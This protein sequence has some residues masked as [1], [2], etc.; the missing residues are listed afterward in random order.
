MSIDISTLLVP[1]LPTLPNLNAT[2]PN[3]LDVQKVA[4]EWLNSLSS[5]I[6]S[7]NPDNA[8][9]R[10][11][12]SQRSYIAS[13]PH[14]QEHSNCV[15]ISWDYTED[16]AWINCFFDFE[17][18]TGIG[19]GIIRLKIR[20]DNGTERIFNVKHV[21]FATGMDGVEPN[22]PN[23][24]D[25][26]KVKG[27]FLHSNKYKR[28]I[29]HEEKKVVVG[30]ACTSGTKFSSF[31]ATNLL[32]EYKPTTLHMIAISMESVDT[33]FS[34]FI[35][36]FSLSHRDV[37]MYQR[38][39]TYIMRTKTG[40]GVVF[41]GL[42][43]EHAPPTDIADR[44]SASFLLYEY[45]TGP[46]FCSA[47]RRARQMPSTNVDLELTKESTVLDINSWS[48]RFLL[49]L[50][51]SSFPDVGASKL[52][53]DGK[54]KLKN[55]SQIKEFTEA[56]LL[57][58]D[59]TKLLEDVVVFATG[60]SDVKQ[61][62]R[63]ICGVEVA[64]KCLPIWGLNKGE[65]NDS[66]RDLGVQGL[67]YMTGNLALCR[68]HSKHVAPHQG[69]GRGSIRLITSKNLTLLTSAFVFHS[70]AWL[71]LVNLRLNCCNHYLFA[72][73]DCNRDMHHPIFTDKPLT[74]VDSPFLST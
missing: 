74:K 39:S 27:Q 36:F 71:D 24:P 9:R 34:F 53:A 57:F 48:K 6:E 32:I 65:A 7:N 47:N 8:A 64:D 38:S 18:D 59:N 31:N 12:L 58:E 22:I 40:W 14:I 2:V 56:V 72:T 62:I 46:A 61:H 42:Y 52:I 69:N 67:W 20:R 66:W 35:V 17:M 70:L 73:G 63:K 55:N 51:D 44:L 3:D 43:S 25:L 30:G 16:L 5:A 1:R 29:D 23:M 45:R 49:P 41:K 15:K 21:V 11:L 19:F 4:S 37:T 10:F 50:T 13:K 26:E 60:L 28:A 68:F 33:Y 54:I